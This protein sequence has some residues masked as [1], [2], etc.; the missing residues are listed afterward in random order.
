MKMFAHVSITAYT[1]GFYRFWLHCSFFADSRLLLI[2][3]KQFPSDLLEFFELRRYW[4]ARE[5][6]DG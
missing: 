2:R 4:N 3:S 6:R 1:Y 5:V